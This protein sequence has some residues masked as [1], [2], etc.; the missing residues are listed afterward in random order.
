[1]TGEAEE[2]SKQ[3]LGLLRCIKRYNLYHI[4]ERGLATTGFRQEVEIKLPFH[5]GGEWLEQYYTESRETSYEATE[6]NK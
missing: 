1:M 4:V 6:I 3:S 2:V 5:S